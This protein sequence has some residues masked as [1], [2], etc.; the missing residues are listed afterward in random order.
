MYR[1]EVQGARPSIAETAAA[2]SVAVR[3]V[4]TIRVPFLIMTSVIGK[5]SPGL[6]PLRGLVFCFAGIRLPDKGVFGCM[7]YR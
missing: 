1:L 4:F 6:G 2:G 5:T 3:V 7:L